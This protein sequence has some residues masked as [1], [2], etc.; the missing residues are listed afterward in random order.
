MNI[1]WESE[2]LAEIHIKAARIITQCINFKKHLPDFG[3]GLIFL[4]IRCI[5]ISQVDSKVHIMK[6]H[7]IVY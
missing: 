2:N 7:V 5:L 4:F 6:A 1:K 3:E